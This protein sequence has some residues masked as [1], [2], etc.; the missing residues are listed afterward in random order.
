MRMFSYCRHFPN[1]PSDV[2]EMLIGTKGVCKVNEYNINRKRVGEDNENPYVQEHIDLIQAIRSGKEL[3]ELKN[4]ADSTM[5]AILGRMATY[6]GQ[7]IKWEDA[8]A[9]KDETMPK[10]L[11]FDTPLKTP[12]VAVPGTTKFV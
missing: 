6:T 3:N 10:N 5:T 12:P 1:T 8:V 9:S 4:V 11:T 7:V 2:S